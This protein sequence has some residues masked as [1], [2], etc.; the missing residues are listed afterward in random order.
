M[1][2]YK[3]LKSAKYI[4]ATIKFA[5]GLLDINFNRIG[6]HRYS[7]Y[8]RFILIE[9]IVSGIMSMVRVKSSLTVSVFKYYPLWKTDI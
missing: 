2:T 9:G 3:D 4:D 7:V 6:K 5:E 1:T 8:C